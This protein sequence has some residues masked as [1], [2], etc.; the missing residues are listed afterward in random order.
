M[1]SARLQISDAHG[2]ILIDACPVERQHF[3]LKVA[4]NSGEEISDMYAHY[5]AFVDAGAGEYHAVQTVARTYVKFG[6]VI[7]EKYDLRITISHQYN[8]RKA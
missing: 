7:Q 4:F 3:L 5:L 6:A 8:K 1:P 2:A